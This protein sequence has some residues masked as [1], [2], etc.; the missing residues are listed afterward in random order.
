MTKWIYRAVGTVGVAAGGVL[1]L[2]GGAAQADGIDAPVNDLRGSLDGFFTPLGDHDVVG[3]TPDLT[4]GQHLGFLAAVPASPT[5][6]VD[7][8][9]LEAGPAPTQ[10]N[11]DDLSLLGVGDKKVTARSL[12]DALNS[13][14]PL[15]EEPAGGQLIKGS[16]QP[17]TALPV[18]GGSPL[19]DN[20]LGALGLGGARE[21]QPLADTLSD[22]NLNTIGSDSQMRT[23]GSTVGVDQLTRGGG[24]GG[25]GD[26]GRGGGIGDLGRG[27]GIGDLGR[28]PLG[29]LTEDPLGAVGKH[30]APD[31]RDF[32]IADLRSMDLDGFD[33][34]DG[35]SGSLVPP[36]IGE[37]LE[38]EMVPGFLA[39]SGLEGLT[40]A[41]G[42]SMIG[43]PLI[44][45][46]PLSPVNTSDSS[47]PLGDLSSIDSLGG[48]TAQP[49]AQTPAPAKAGQPS[50]A[51]TST[52]AS[53]QQRGHRQWS[54]SSS[55]RPVA[56]EDSAFR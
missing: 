11:S 52:D 56:G 7:P 14:G 25:F 43:L 28:G 35:V 4:P 12:T 33:D 55:E 17:G 5:A 53:S 10:L 27:G 41:D 22:D 19:G 9:A 45:Q 26:L 54:R 3:A 31:Q 18:L 29:E 34:L 15:V 50:V 21:A 47:G 39:S 32:D 24:L 38:A 6:G 42:D 44:G 37:A 46:L 8:A 30:A 36:L 20:P 23:L 16:A 13:T 2:A 48:S 1:L 49:A 51:P 40:E